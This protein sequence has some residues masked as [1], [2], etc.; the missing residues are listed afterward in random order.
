MLNL[1]LEI[2]TTVVLVLL[3]CIAKLSSLAL[4]I[5]LFFSNE[6]TIEAIKLIAISIVGFLGCFA[7]VLTITFATILFSN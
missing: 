1:L 3:L 7:F 2:R 6:N 4:N 5:K